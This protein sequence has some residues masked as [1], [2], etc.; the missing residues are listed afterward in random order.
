[1]ANEEQGSKALEY[2][3]L[4]SGKYAVLDVDKKYLDPTV[5]GSEA[6]AKTAKEAAAKRYADN[7]KYGVVKAK[8][9][10]KK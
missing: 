10:E 2:V 1:M 4:A 8:P 9:W 5:Y 7:G 3:K 6:D